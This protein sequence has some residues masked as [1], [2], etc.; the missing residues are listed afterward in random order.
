MMSRRAFLIATGSMAGLSLGLRPAQAQS[1][2]TG[3]VRIIV[4]FPPGGG[5]DVLGR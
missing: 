2:P 4:P 3:L 1:F 5:T